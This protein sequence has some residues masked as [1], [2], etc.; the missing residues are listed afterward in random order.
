MILDIKVKVIISV[1]GGIIATV[2]VYNPNYF[3]IHEMVGFFL[4]GLA[5]GSDTKPKDEMPD[6]IK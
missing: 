5:C 2:G 6:W 1:V 3:V 4:M